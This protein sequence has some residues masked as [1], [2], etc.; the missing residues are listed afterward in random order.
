MTK[1]IMK[2]NI[3]QL[4]L[5]AAMTCPLMAIEPPVE[6]EPIAPGEPVGEI[7]AAKVVPMPEVVVA[8]PCIGVILSPIPE[9][10]VG[11]LKLV[12]GEGVVVFEAVAGGAAETAGLEPND[13][14]TRIGGNLVGSPEQVRAEVEAHAVGDEIELD[15]IH[16]GESKKMKLTLGDSSL[17]P[18][19]QAQFLPLGMGR[20]FG[21]GVGQ[22]DGVLE[23]LPQKHADLIREAMKLNR[24]AFENMGAQAQVPEEMHRE[25]LQRLERGFQGGAGDAM[26]KAEIQLDFG[27]ESTIRLMDD[28]GSIELRSNDGHKE[29]K[30]FDKSGKLLW[31]GPYDTEQDKAAVPDGIRERIG[32]VDVGVN[33]DGGALRLKVGPERFRRLED[34]EPQR[35]APKED[36]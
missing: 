9:I 31:E 10:L 30:A 21:G 32:R 23:N 33:V 25:L 12:D 7:P 20:G 14:I 36:K 27:A 3:R 15:V 16:A 8:R 22:L 17:M 34:M 26:R 24:D 11:H 18:M 1:T 6:S 2:T 29:A 35:R 19:A 28:Q 4:L 5:L 13:V